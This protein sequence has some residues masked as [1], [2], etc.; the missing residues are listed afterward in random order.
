MNSQDKVRFIWN[1][2][3]LLDGSF[4]KKDYERV[5]LPMMVLRRYDCENKFEKLLT[6]ADNIAFNL[7][8]YINGLSKS[9]IDILRFFDFEKQIEKMDRNNLLYLVTKAFSEV[10]LQIGRAHV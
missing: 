5:I 8:D 3:K 4:K 1:I 9:L 10:N 7:R 2:A 6:D